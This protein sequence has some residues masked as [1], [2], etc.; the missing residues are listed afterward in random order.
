MSENAWSTP[1]EI[2][3]GVHSVVGKVR[4]HN[5]DAYLVD[6][7]LG[8]Y[9]VADGL[10]GHQ[11]G[12]HASSLAVQ[13]L[14]AQLGRVHELGVA[15]SLD[16][17][18]EAFDRANLGI[19]EDADAHPERQGMGTTLTAMLIY[20]R[21]LLLAH[22]GDSRAW[23]IR[24]GQ[25]EQLTRDHTIVEEQVRGGVLSAE[26]AR[27]HPMRHILSRC[28]GIRAEIQVDLVEAD[29]SVD[30]IYVLVSDGLTPGCGPE[31]M[32]ALIRENPVAEQ[33]ARVL[34]SHACEC[35]G[36]DNITAVVVACREG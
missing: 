23:R 26:D 27:H 6:L 8:I 30:D 32:M 2:D 33:A 3:A 21:R 18:L 19:L 36:Q 7:A 9:A 4:D 16:S 34:V 14:G 25:I 31:D 22:V 35:D 24:D 17:L 5:E 10:G 29:V 28:L 1:F 20:G 11:A 12:E 13:V 15:P